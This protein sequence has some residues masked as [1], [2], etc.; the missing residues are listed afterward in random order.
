MLFALF[1]ILAYN[2]YLQFIPLSFLVQTLDFPLSLLM[3]LNLHGTTITDLI[4]D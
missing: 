2:I 3:L 4:Q 1:L